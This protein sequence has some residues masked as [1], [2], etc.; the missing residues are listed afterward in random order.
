MK[1]IND[2][3]PRRVRA[4]MY[5]RGITNK[6]IANQESVSEIYVTFVVNGR[7]KGYRIRE[8]IA[9]A[10]GLKVKDLWPDEDPEDPEMPE[11]A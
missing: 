9:K 1:A 6:L 7:R 3:H 5:E 4:A 10:C 11:A 2:L 8:A